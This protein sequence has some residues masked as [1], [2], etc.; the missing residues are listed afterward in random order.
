M[1][2]RAIIAMSLALDPKL[3]LADEPTTALDVI[4]QEQIL[5]RLNELQ[6]ELGSSMLMITHDISV[7][8]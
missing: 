4:V 8:A 5:Y 6:R 7:V 2:Q 1:R 3:V